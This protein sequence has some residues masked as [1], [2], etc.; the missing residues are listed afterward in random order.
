[1]VK[2]C[3]YVLRNAHFKKCSD[4]FISHSGKKD[5]VCC[6]LTEWKKKIGVCPYDKTIFSS[7]NNIRKLI[8][9]NKQKTL[10]G[11]NGQ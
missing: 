5:R 2:N 1:M 10:G 4:Y 3:K 7:P 11:L 8:Q 6:R 9:D